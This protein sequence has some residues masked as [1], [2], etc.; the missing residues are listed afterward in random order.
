ML[1]PDQKPR[2]RDEKTEA[3][4][5]LRSLPKAVRLTGAE[6]AL[7]LESQEALSRTQ[8]QTRDCLKRANAH[9]KC[10]FPLGHVIDMQT[11]KITA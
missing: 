10:F 7:E 4:T 11:F 5:G 2:F 9:F 3:P 6:P 1:G 8:S